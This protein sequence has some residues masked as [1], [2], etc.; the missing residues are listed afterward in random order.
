VE[1]S[2]SAA[3]HEE[4]EIAPVVWFRVDRHGWLSGSVEVG[5][6]R[7]RI[8]KFCGAGKVLMLTRKALVRSRG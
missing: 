3:E 6:S 2:D 7:E 4:I 1:T 5:A 8:T